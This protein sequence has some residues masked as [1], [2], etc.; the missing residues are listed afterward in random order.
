MMQICERVA[1]DAECRGHEQKTVLG[2]S[3]VSQPRDLLNAPRVTRYTH[4][5]RDHRR[6]GAG[7]VSLASMVVIRRSNSLN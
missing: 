7:F 6:P 4:V 1:R 3:A 2:T 5:G